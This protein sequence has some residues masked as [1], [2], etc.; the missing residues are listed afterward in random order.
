[1]N[2]LYKKLGDYFIKYQ[3]AKLVRHALAAVSGYLLSATAIQSADEVNTVAGLLSGLAMLLISTAWSYA[4]KER[5]TDKTRDVLRNVLGALTRQAVAA[6]SGMLLSLEYTG[7]TGDTAA[8]M[9]FLGNY[10]WSAIKNT[11][12]AVIVKALLFL[13]MP[14]PLIS[15]V[16]YSN[17]QGKS[18]T[19]L[20]LDAG[21]INV[22]GEL[23]MHDVNMSRSVEHG[24]K[25][26]QKMWNSYLIQQGLQFVAGKYYDFKGKELASTQSVKLEELRN[27]QSVDMANIKLKELEMMHAAEAVNVAPAQF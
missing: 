20:G 2:I 22:E 6:V 17:G 27:A 14:L 23:I 15:C 5:M 25:L 10:G 11:D 12:K 9:V 7:D 24:T 4:A 8:V 19:A 3:L 1:M 16:H 26:I 13:C 21:V 18:F